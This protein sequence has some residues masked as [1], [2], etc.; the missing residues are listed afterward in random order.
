MVG[1]WSAIYLIRQ[2]LDCSNGEERTTANVYT[3]L[4]LIY[5]MAEIKDLPKGVEI[6]PKVK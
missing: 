4:C 1:S 2:D 3:Q 5:F 6:K